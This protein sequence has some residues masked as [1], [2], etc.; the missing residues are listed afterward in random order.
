MS[1]SKDSTTATDQTM[2]APYFD[3]RWE[4]I[5]ATPSEQ[6]ITPLFSNVFERVGSWVVDDEWMI[7]RVQDSEH[8]TTEFHF[9]SKAEAEQFCE[10]Q[11]QDDELSIVCYD[12]QSMGAWNYAVTTED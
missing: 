12:N 9:E 6:F 2:Q 7:V 10:Q 8:R 4:E 11:L 5:A 1:T 3:N